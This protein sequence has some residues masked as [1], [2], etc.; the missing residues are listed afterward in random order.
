MS[1]RIF[2]IC[3]EAFKDLRIESES[4]LDATISDLDQRPETILMILGRAEL[5]I[6]DDTV[7][8]CFCHEKVQRAQM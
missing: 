5:E 7:A 4:D 8:R 6:R 1:Q 3:A 2:Q